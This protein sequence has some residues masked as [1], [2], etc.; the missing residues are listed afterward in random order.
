ML[1]RSGGVEHR[2]ML[3]NFANRVAE[4]GDVSK[5]GI[6]TRRDG[7][8]SLRRAERDLHFFGGEKAAALRE[9]EAV[10]RDLLPRALVG[11]TGLFGG[12]HG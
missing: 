10:E 11:F 1:A 2:Q 3:P 6:L 12:V 9:F 7:G 8:R 5:K 4:F